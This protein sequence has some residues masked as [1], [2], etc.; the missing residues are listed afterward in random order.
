MQGKFVRTR[1]DDG[2][3]Y[4]EIAKPKANTY[5]LEMMHEVD[6]A[7]EELRFDEGAKVIVLTSALPGFFSAGADIEMLKKSHP[8]FKAMFCLFC[9]E[10][11]NKFA[12]TPKV[13]IAALP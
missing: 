9:Q 12:Q 6:S 10:T 4:I 1:I 5:D 7:L 2:V 11:L 3:G 13:V 8:D